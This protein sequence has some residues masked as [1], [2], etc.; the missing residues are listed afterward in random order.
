M[1]TATPPAAHRSPVTS[2]P[3]SPPAAPEIWTVL[4][5][6]DDGVEVQTRLSKPQAQRLERELAGHGARG[7]T[8]EGSS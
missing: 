3:V 4:H 5:R 1:P 7:V 2:P 8:V 6:C